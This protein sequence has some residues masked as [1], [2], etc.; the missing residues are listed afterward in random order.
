VPTFQELGLRGIDKNPWLAF[1]GPPNLPADFVDRFTK[2]VATV[3]Q[4]PEVSEKLGAVGN[5]ATYATPAE[6]REWVSSATAHW[7]P[8][9]K[10]SGYVPQ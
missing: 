4:T 7:G 6:L 8:V 5:E 3:L 2:A 1:F 10:E 9:I